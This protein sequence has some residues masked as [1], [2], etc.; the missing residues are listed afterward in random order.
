MTETIAL[1]PIASNGASAAVLRPAPLHIKIFDAAR[2]S[3]WDAFVHREPSATFF[4]L[5]GWMKVMERTFGYR[6][7][8]VYSERNGE[9]TGIL[10]LFL[11]KNWITG[12]CLISTPFAVYGGI[13]ASDSESFTALVEHARNMALDQNVQ[14]L[15]LRNREGE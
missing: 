3:Q 1:K 4:H 11:T 5:S 9:I 15:E 7:C 8:A 14:Y 12:P 10:P 13:A 2:A 6:A